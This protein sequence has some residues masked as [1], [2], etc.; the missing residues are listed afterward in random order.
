[1]ARA[2]TLGL[3]LRSPDRRAYSGSSR[4]QVVRAGI[5]LGVPFEL[6]LSCMNPE[7]G[8]TNPGSRIP[9]SRVMQ[10][11]VPRAPRRALSS[12]AWPIRPVY[13][14]QRYVRA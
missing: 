1:M 13:E 2:L 6:T 10:Q 4:A 14:D 9:Q 12:W 5:E 8:V 11:Q 7:S 3:A